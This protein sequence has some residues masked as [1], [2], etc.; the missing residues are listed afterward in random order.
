MCVVPWAVTY[1]CGA[2]GGVT[3]VCGAMGGDSYVCGAMGSHLCVWCHGGDSYVCGIPHIAIVLWEDSTSSPLHM[4]ISTLST[5]Q[6][7]M[8][9][10]QDLLFNQDN[11]YSATYRDRSRQWLHTKNDN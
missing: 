11:P 10:C 5:F 8:V 7:L 1:V 6:Q 3:Y 2:M 9:F 4:H